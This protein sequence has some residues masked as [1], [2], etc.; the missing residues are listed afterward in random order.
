MKSTI[1]K[2]AIT[3]EEHESLIWNIYQNWCESASTTVLEYQ[4]VLANASI[5]RWFMLELTKC[6]AEFHKLTDRYENTSVTAKDMEKCYKECAIGLFNIR[7][8]ALLHQIAKP[9]IDKGI[10]VFNA[11]YPN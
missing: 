10:R 8:M 5:N 2:L 1:Q 11:L 7:P 3:P 4:Q 6:E 9:K